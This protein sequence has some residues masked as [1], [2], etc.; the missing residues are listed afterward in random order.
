MQPN[1]YLNISLVFTDLLSQQAQLQ[2]WEVGVWQGWSWVCPE[3]SPSRLMPTSLQTGSLPQH[4]TNGGLNSGGRP[5][6]QRPCALPGVVTTLTPD[7]LTS[8][9]VVEAHHQILIE[10]G[11]GALFLSTGILMLLIP[12]QFSF[13]P[14]TLSCSHVVSGPVSWQGSVWSSTTSNTGEKLP[15]VRSCSAG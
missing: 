10:V 13:L 11:V 9:E 1:K 14:P 3:H 5:P 12:I 8:P 15:P 2:G 6:Q 7:L 4:P